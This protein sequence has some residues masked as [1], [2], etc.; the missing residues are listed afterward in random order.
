MSD[1]RTLSAARRGYGHAWR[2]ARAAFLRSHPLC[3]L[4]RQAGRISAASIVDHVRP[5]RLGHAITSG[6]PAV[7]AAARR[8]FWDSRNWQSLCA[9]CHSSAKQTAERSGLLP[10]AD[11]DGLPL[12]PGH[13]WIG[14]RS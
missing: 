12:D 3:E 13:H 14:G 8:L 5:H 10:G 11:A 2:Q 4:C 9:S 6:D 1:D 7:I